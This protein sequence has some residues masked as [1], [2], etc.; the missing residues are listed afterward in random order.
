[1]ADTRKNPDL[2]QPR[3]PIQVVARRTGLTA[4]VIRVWERRYGVVS[5]HR[6]SA[7]RRLYSDADIRKLSLL[8]RA[9]QEGR[10]ISDLA[11]LEETEILA[12][13]GAGHSN[14]PG[15]LK[16]KTT[17]DAAGSQ[18]AQACLAAIEQLDQPAL[19]Q[20]LSNASVALSVPELLEQVIAP[21]MKQLGK[22]WEKGKVRVGHEHLATATIR[23]FLG[24]LVATA[25]ASNS[26]P[27]LLVATPAGQNHEIGAL[28]SAVIAAGDGWRVAYLAPNIPARDLAAVVK[29]QHPAAIILGITYPPDDPQ[30][31]QELRLLRKHIPDHVQLIAG[32]AAINGYRSVLKEIGATSVRDLNK[33][34]DH[35]RTIRKG[36]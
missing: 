30:I 15:K 19:E 20:A 17:I 2:D 33:F 29:Q 14:Q 32:G 1:M 35:L 7:Q 5:P 31:I 4:D 16:T 8:Q 34:R 18:Y 6:S 12:L 36:G 13:L 25:N 11:D 22:R 3:H 26:G 27:L 28:M 23:S 9:T 24:H 21:F 10:R